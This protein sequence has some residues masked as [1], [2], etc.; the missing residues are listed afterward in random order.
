MAGYRILDIHPFAPYT[1]TV[2]PGVP[3]RLRASVRDLPL[4]GGRGGYIHMTNTGTIHLRDEM[5]LNVASLLMEDVGSRR[6]VT[7]DL[8]NFPLDGELAAT[9]TTADVRLTRIRS[10]L[11][12]QGKVSGT[13]ELECARCL[14]L[15]GQPFTTDFAEEF[16]QTVDVRNGDGVT[17]ARQRR[18]MQDDDD[19]ISFEINDSHEIDMTELLRQ[20]ILLEMPMR[21]DCGDICPGPPEVPK[22]P[23]ADVDS[24]FAAL[25]HLLEDE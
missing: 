4:T 15:Y 11:L 10:G 8:A 24:R 13:V 21:P 18:E 17:A 5:R 9:D 23:D 3:R 14:T 2:T 22:D 12:A 20:W 25:Q 1:D 7:I 6:D 19:D 16:Y